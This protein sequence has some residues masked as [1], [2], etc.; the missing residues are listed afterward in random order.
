[1]SQRVIS[2]YVTVAA[3]ESET[4]ASH[5]VLN[6]ALVN[7]IGP[8]DG[9]ADGSILTEG[10]ADGC[11]LTEGLAEGTSDGLADG[12]MLTDGIAEGT[13]DGTSD[14]FADGSMLT[15]GLADGTSDGIADGLADGTSDAA[16]ALISAKSI[17]M[18]HKRMLMKEN[19]I[20]CLIVTSE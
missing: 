11:M 7:T 13:S 15:E 1:V 14:G 10:L 18:T 5:A 17:T 12:S 20:W 9:L 8:A 19:F 6:S 2:P 3:V 16:S 4:Q